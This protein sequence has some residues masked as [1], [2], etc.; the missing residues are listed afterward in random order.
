LSRRGGIGKAFAKAPVAAMPESPAVLDEVYTLGDIA[1]AAGVSAAVVLDLAARGALPVIG[2]LDDRHPLDTA[3]ASGVAVDAVRTLAAGDTPH[4]GTRAAVAVAPVV[5][6][7]RGVPVLVSTGLHGL[8]ALVVAGIASLGLTARAALPLE[9]TVSHEPA[10]LVFLAT[11]GPGGG[12]AAGAAAT[13]CPLRRPSARAPTRS[14]APCPP[15]NCHHRPPR[16]NPWSH[17]GPSR[18]RCCLR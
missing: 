6:Q 15:A 12:A 1:D 18:R 8:A 7:A 14:P 10:R 2:A 17:H 9:E 3:V 11:P 13:P 5:A 4:G 16:R